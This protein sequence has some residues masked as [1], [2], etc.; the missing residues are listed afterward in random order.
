MMK[1]SFMGFINECVN[2]IKYKVERYIDINICDV[3]TCVTYCSAVGLY[4]LFCWH[5]NQITIFKRNV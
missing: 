3:C 2:G 5:I 1:L 4:P